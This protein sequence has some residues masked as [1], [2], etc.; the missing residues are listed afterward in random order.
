M[1]IY[2][3]FYVH[4][5]LTISLALSGLQM[6]IIRDIRDMPSYDYVS[7]QFDSKVTLVLGLLNLGVNTKYSTKVGAR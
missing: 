1:P 4:N 5:N 2:A 6:N 3:S 7:S